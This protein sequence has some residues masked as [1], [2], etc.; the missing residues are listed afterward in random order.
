MPYGFVA[1]IFAVSGIG[2]DSGSPYTVA[3]DEKTVVRVFVGLE[4]NPD[5]PFPRYGLAMELKNGGQLAEAKAEF[6]ELERRQPEYVAQYLM[7][8]NVLVAMGDKPAAIAVGQ[9]GIDIARKKGDFHTLNEIQAAL[10][11]I[12]DDD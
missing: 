9:R 10:D 4:S 7:H 2:F 6:E 12:E 5:D 11:S 8:H 3:E 1:P